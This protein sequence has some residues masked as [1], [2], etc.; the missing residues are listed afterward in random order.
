MDQ[1]HVDT[2]LVVVP[3]VMAGVAQVAAIF[4]K[5]DIVAKVTIVSRLWDFL[6]GNYRK[7][8]NADQK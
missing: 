1:Q 8:R 5:P 6:A 7:A 2:A 4:G 3:L